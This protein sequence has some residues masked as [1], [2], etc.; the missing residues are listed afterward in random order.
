MKYLIICILLFLSGCDVESTMSEKVSLPLI[1]DI[2]ESTWQKLFQRRIYFGHQSVG[3]NL[4]QG[5]N[6]LK[7]IYPWLNLSIESFDDSINTEAPQLIHSL[8]GE[9]GKPGAKNTD[10]EKLLTGK[11]K[12]SVDVAFFKYCYVD[13]EADTDIEKVFKEYKNTIDTI[14]NSNPEIVIV[15]FTSPLTENQSGIKGFIKKVLGKPVGEMLEN[16]KR[17]EYN[18]MI[19]D[20]YE[21]DGLVFDLAGYEATRKD[22]S[23]NLFKY[24]GKDYKYLAHDYSS[25]GGHLN[26]A[27]QKYI[28][29]KFLVFLAQN[30]H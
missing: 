12:A 1:S 11:L 25:D 17:N 29:E 9:N 23:L 20:E 21:Q 16:V 5:I 7:N 13:F 3:N 26:K 28:A 15:H 2:P 14:K 22:G 19:L 4:L 30:I 27:G 10:V 6:E 24:K 8:I 18:Q